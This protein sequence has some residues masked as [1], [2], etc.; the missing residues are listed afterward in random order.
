MPELPEVEC[1]RQGI[2]AA[3]AQKTVRRVWHDGMPNLLDAQSLP[4]KNLVGESL[5]A[6]ERRGKY[7]RWLTEKYQ[8]LAHLGMSGVFAVNGNRTAHTH[9]ELGFDNGTLCY[10]DPRRF[11]Y[12]C[13]LPRGGESKRWSALGPDALDRACTGTRMAQTA[14]GSVVAIKNWILDQHHLAGVG[15]IYACE[16]LFRAGIHPERGAASLSGEEWRRLVAELKAVMRAS[17]RNRGTTFSDYRLTNG[18]GGAFQTFLQVFQKEGTACSLCGNVIQ[19]LVQTG[20]ST[21][22]CPHCQK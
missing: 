11:G 5:L 18:R 8:L 19:R 21:F 9:L 17:I 4:L 10:T 1:V 14:A 7:L 2:W 22:Y 16:G 15:N 12:F 3:C 13:L 20:R 6:L